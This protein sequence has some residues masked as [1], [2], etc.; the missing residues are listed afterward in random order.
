M[1]YHV[2]ML[3]NLISPSAVSLLN[4]LRNCIRQIVDRW[5]VLPHS[6]VIVLHCAHHRRVM[7]SN[8]NLIIS[9]VLES[10]WSEVKEVLL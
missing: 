9:L 7:L 4:V 5:P 1:L 6:T 10:H 8:G 3:F 2:S